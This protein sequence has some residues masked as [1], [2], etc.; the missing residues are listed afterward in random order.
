MSIRKLPVDTLSA[1]YSLECRAGS[2]FYPKVNTTWLISVI[3]SDKTTAQLNLAA[4]TR[5]GH[6]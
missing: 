1:E 3:V 4:T 2:I 6:K 5:I